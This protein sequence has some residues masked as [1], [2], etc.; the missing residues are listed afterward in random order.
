LN[1]TGCGKTGFYHPAGRGESKN[2]QPNQYRDAWII[3]HKSNPGLD[4]GF[5]SVSWVINQ[6]MPGA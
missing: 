4:T 3:W 2:C 6:R 5:F 1:L